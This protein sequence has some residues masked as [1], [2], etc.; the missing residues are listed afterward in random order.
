MVVRS[1]FIYIFINIVLSLGR[2]RKI[3]REEKNYSSVFFSSV[4]GAW[5]L[6]W[7]GQINERKGTQILCDV[8]ILIFTC[9]EAFIEKQLGPQTSS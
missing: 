2:P 6:N 1:Q 4:T 3:V 8:S 5:E 9:M 7:Q